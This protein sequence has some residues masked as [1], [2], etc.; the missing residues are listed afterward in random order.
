MRT[1]YARIFGQQQAGV[2]QLPD[3]FAIQVNTW[4]AMAAKTEET[5]LVRFGS[6]DQ[7]FL[8]GKKPSHA[9]TSWQEFLVDGFLFQRPEL[10]QSCACFML[11]NMSA[12]SCAVEEMMCDIMC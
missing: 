8:Q 9:Q 11:C 2:M 4:R 12:M 1:A 7:G 3:W 5:K 10:S 6:T